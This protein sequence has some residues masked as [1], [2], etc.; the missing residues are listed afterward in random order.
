MKCEHSCSWGWYFDAFF[1]GVRRQLRGTSAGLFAG[2]RVKH[3]Y[4]L[5]IRAPTLI[6][7]ETMAYL[8]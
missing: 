8:K 7:E 5:P 2:P 3:Y 1:R 4:Y 6:L